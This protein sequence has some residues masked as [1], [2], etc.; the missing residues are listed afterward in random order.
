M[1]KPWALF[2]GC[3]LAAA[4]TACTGNPDTSE[5][6]LP[7]WDAELDAAIR[8]AFVGG[9]FPAAWRFEC[10]NINKLGEPTPSGAPPFQAA[11]LNRLWLSDI[12][13][14]RLNIL[15]G[16]D[17]LDEANQANVYIGSGIGLDDASQCREPTTDG[18]RFQAP[19]EREASRFSAADP[20]AAGACAVPAEASVKAFGTVDVA[21]PSTSAIYIYAQNDR[22]VYY[23][24]TPD[25]ALPQ[26]V[27]LRYVSAV[28]SVSE[29][30]GAISGEL[31]ACLLKSDI[32]TLCSCIGDCLASD[33]TDVIADGQCGGCPRGAAPLT[34]QLNGLIGSPGCTDKAGGEA[35]ELKAT[36]NARRLPASPEICGA[37]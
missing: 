35:F 31:T 16:I 21:V 25:P 5:N 37:P 30:T 14:H 24:C 18:T 11:V 32:L 19:V 2:G 20:A 6:L 27:P 10:I 26:A 28:V 12:A 29:D 8:D 23:N 36:F 17:T 15:I 7:Q 34:A 9:P 3:A 22:E 33:P 4:A 1:F 13:D